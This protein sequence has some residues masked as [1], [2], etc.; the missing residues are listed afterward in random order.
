MVGETRE[1]K[2]NEG[3]VQNEGANARGNKQKECP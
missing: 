3:D 2:Q 1:R